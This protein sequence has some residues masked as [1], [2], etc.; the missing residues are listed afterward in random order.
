M[1]LAAATAVRDLASAI[2]ARAVTESEPIGLLQCSKRENCDR[3]GTRA[4]RTGL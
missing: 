2:P 1:I 4:E 3:A